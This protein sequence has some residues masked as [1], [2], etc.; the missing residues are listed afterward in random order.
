MSI[1]DYNTTVQD[2]PNGQKISKDIE[3]LFHIINK[4]DLLDIYQTSQLDNWKT[5]SQ[6][7]K[8]YW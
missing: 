5:L 7:P 1:T 4:V 6:A 8:E 2:R 3:D